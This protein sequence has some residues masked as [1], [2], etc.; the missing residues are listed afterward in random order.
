[1][2][3]RSF[4]WIACLSMMG[5]SL[6]PLLQIL[7]TSFLQQIHHSILTRIMGGISVPKGFGALI[8]ADNLG[9]LDTLNV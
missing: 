7:H 8:V 4:L 1:M 6:V 3:Q 5:N 9:Q 2:I